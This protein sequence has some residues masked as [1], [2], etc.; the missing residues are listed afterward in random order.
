MISVFQYFSASDLF[1]VKTKIIFRETNEVL[2]VGDFLPIDFHGF[3][4]VMA[5]ILKYEKKEKNI[6][7]LRHSEL[8]IRVTSE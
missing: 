1:H 3:Q 6:F 7:G 5:W 8:S 4:G 2:E